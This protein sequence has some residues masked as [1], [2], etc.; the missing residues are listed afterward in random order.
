MELI[1]SKQ[2]K[3]TLLKMEPKIIYCKPQTETLFLATEGF[4]CIS[5]QGLKTLII[6]DYDFGFEEE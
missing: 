3:I 1:C 6:E 5:G 2:R 4:L